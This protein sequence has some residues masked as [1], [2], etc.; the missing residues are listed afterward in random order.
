MRLGLGAVFV[1]PSKLKLH[2]E[3]SSTRVHHDI[4]VRIHARGS[5]W[6]ELTL[7]WQGAVMI[8]CHIQSE[9]K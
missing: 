9:L 2:A 3:I 8:R 6:M 7:T 5:S 1:E 4:Y